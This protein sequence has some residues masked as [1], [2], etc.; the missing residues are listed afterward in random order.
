MGWADYS[1][2]A[3]TGKRP[4]QHERWG[5]CWQTSSLG[6]DNSADSYLPNDIF[7]AMPQWRF[8]SYL[9]AI[10]AANEAARRVD[11][12]RAEASMSPASKPNRRGWAER[13][14]LSAKIGGLFSPFFAAAYH[15]GFDG[16]WL[17]I[18]WLG[19]QA[20]WFGTSLSDPD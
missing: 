15:S 17:L 3:A 19:L 14:G 7:N 8:D 11:R 9:D 10:A 4:I 1:Y 12:D 16:T 18:W 5:W 2:T 13:L 20:L 6:L